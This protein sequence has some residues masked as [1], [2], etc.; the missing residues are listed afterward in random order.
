MHFERAALVLFGLSDEN[1]TNEGMELQN[2][3][4]DTSFGK[5]EDLIIPFARAF[6]VSIENLYEPM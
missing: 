5:M 3:V 1:M 6:R 4:G 2:S